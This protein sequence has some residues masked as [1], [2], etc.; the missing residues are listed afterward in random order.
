[1]IARAKPY[2]G[3][4]IERKLVNFQLQFIAVKQR[5]EIAKA[6]SVRELHLKLDQILKA[7]EKKALVEIVQDPASRV[8]TNCGDACQNNPNALV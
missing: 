8:L 4:R 1:M 7:R 2:L 5:R 6:F 3:H